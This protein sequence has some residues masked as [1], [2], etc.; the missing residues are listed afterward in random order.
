MDNYTM[1]KPTEHKS[2][3]ARIIEYAEEI[4]WNYVSQSEAEVRR[5]FDQS[6]ASPRERAKHASRFFTDLL[7]EKVKAV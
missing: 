6:A 3:Q 5:G 1:S 2:V 4:G 7:Y